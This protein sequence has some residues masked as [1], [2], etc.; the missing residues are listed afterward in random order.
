MRALIVLSGFLA[1]Q[2]CVVKDQPGSDLTSVRRGNAKLI[3]CSHAHPHLG[4]KRVEHIAVYEARRNGLV[5]LSLENP[6]SMNWKKRD[7]EF[8]SLVLETIK[9]KDPDYYGLIKE[10]LNSFDAGEGVTYEY[11]NHIGKAEDEDEQVTLPSGNFIDHEGEEKYNPAYHSRP[12]DT[13]AMIIRT[14]RDLSH[15]RYQV[16]KN[17]WHIDLVPETRNPPQGYKA[18]DENLDFLDYRGRAAAKIEDMLDSFELA[19]AN[20]VIDYV[21][22]LVS[23][24]FAEM[25][26][27]EYW[28]WKKDHRLSTKYHM[29]KSLHYYGGLK[30]SSVKFHQGT[31]LVKEGEI[32]TD[33]MTQYGLTG[34]D[35]YASLGKTEYSFTFNYGNVEFDQDQNVTEV[36]GGLRFSHNHDHKNQ[37]FIRF[38][39]QANGTLKLENKKIKELYDFSGL[40]T[41]NCISS[42]NGGYVS[43]KSA[44]FSDDGQLT[45]A[46]IGGTSYSFDASEIPV[47]KYSVALMTDKGVLKVFEAGDRII[48]KDYVVQSVIN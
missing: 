36:W 17:R 1:L 28:N 35:L 37:C 19:H 16:A 15:H 45:E 12:C 32:L 41:L 29:D 6:E 11:A 30:M 3:K 8:Q 44:K 23:G 14:S 25:S 5:P 31:R 24:K 39:R 48:V 26:Y 9:D 4:G 42:R 21:A 40:K 22:H 7:Q 13:S 34:L 27:I 20:D 33:K 10:K 47:Q 18:L 2:S 43:L 46:V 38:D